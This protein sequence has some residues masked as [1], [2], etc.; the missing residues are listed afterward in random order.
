MIWFFDGGKNPWHPFYINHLFHPP[1]L[2]IH[3]SGFFSVDFFWSELFTKWGN[4]KLSKM[5]KC[6]CVCVRACACMCACACVCAWSTAKPLSTWGMWEIVLTNLKKIYCSFSWQK[7][8][9]LLTVI[10]KLVLTSLV[11]FIQDWSLWYDERKLILI[12]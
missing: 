11:T 5:L 7:S 1:S 6:V 10:S 8:K 3:P 2:A 9:Y 12:K 4:L